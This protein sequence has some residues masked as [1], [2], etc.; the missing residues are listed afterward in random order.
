MKARKGIDRKLDLL[1]K[2]CPY[3]TLDTQTALREMTDGQTL[4]VV[5]DYYPARQTIPELLRELGYP[6]ELLDD[7]ERS[8]RFVIRK[9]HAETG[10]G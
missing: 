8:F 2:V 10:P 4:E 6:Y 5:S 3:P 7:T 1:G 9:E